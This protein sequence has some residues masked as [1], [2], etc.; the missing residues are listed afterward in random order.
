MSSLEFFL[1]RSLGRGVA[2]GLLRL[3]WIIHC[4]ADHFPDDAQF[5]PDEEWLEYGLDRG[6]VPLCKDGR[7]KGRP[8]ERRPVE[9]KGAVLFY[10]DNQQL[11]RDEMISRFHGAH[12]AIHRA[13]LRGGPAIYA[14]KS[15]GIRRT[16]P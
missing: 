12:D 1:D 10:L 9:A 3:E 4:I 16:W 2:E 5:T 13:V 7:I 8:S 14:V 11:R 6:W 15:D